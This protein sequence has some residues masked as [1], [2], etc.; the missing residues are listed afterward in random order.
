MFVHAT[1]LETALANKPIAKE[2]KEVIQSS[3]A[4]HVRAHEQREESAPRVAVGVVRRRAEQ[5][6]D[7]AAAA[8]RAGG[9]PLRQLPAERVQGGGGARR[10][11]AL[12]PPL[13]QVRDT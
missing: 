12:P 10:Q 13:L 7:A 5:P 2:P 4:P 9:A 1:L 6:A 3:R 8:V 11:P